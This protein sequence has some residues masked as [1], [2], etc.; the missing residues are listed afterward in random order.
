MVRRNTRRGGTKMTETID[1]LLKK[2]GERIIGQQKNLR[3]MLTAALAGGHVLIEGVPGTGK[4]QMVKTLAGLLDADFN[5]VQFTPDLLPSDITGNAIFNMKEQSFQD[6][7]S[8][9]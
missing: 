7:K 2:Y 5:R 1:G 9:V 8:V 6:R 3:Y 4:T